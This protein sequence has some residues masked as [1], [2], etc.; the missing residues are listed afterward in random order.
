MEPSKPRNSGASARS[1]QVGN[2]STGS[3]VGGKPILLVMAK[4]L[5]DYYQE[6]LQTLSHVDRRVFRKELRKAMRRI[7]PAD[8][9]KLK[10][11]FRSACLCRVD[12]AAVSAVPVETKR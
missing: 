6:L 3:T 1:G 9:E 8:R 2:H 5:A 7:D 12:H 4:P 10:A 11:W